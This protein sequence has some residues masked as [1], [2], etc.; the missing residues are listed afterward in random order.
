MHNFIHKMY[1]LFLIL[2]HS[3][4]KS[5]TYALAFITAVFTLTPESLYEKKEWI[6]QKTFDSIDFLSRFER[7]DINVT[8]SRIGLFFSIWIVLLVL[9]ILWKLVYRKVTIHGNNYSISVEYGNLFKTKGCKRVIPFDECY[10]TKVGE[11]IGDINPTSIC[12]QYLKR[13]PDLDIEKLIN[14]A[15]IIPERS[16]SRFQNQTRYKSGTIVP[17]GNDLLLAFANLDHRGKGH[18]PTRDEYLDCLNTMWQEIEYYY[19]E[20]DVCIPILGAGTTVF[21]G[22]SGA[23]YSQQELLDMIILS[24]KLS[25]HKIKSPHKLRII[26]K[27]NQDFSIYDI[28][29]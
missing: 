20:E 21:E 29:R 10:T 28:D 26:C 6:S 19:S 5:L 9:G 16:K 4:K 23:S 24:Y 13:H 22:N 7:K 27:S 25:S 1:N 18:F 8:I 15:G 3:F 2:K 11:G 14:N 12:G 17:N